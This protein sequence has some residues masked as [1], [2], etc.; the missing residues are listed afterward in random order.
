M[1]LFAA[2]RDLAALSER[3]QIDLSPDS[4]YVRK[5]ITEWLQSWKAMGWKTAAK[6]PVESK[7]MAMIGSTTGAR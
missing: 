7:L 3:C 4:Q 1:E 6:K 2:I 5:G